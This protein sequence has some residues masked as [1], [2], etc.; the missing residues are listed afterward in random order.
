MKQ[1]LILAFAVVGIII[2]EDDVDTVLRLGADRFLNQVRF[3]TT[4]ENMSCIYIIL[5]ELRQNQNK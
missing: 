1:D 5:C 4:E 2:T 3:T